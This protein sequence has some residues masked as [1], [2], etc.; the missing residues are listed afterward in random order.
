ML[1]AVLAVI[2]YLAARSDFGWMS[3]NP[4][5][6]LLLP[7]LIG[8]RYGVVAGLL[9][10]LLGGV[11]IAAVNAGT[12]GL[13]THQ[14]V[15]Q[16]P[17][18]FAL[19]ILTGYLAGECQRLLWKE[20]L[21]LRAQTKRQGDDNDRLR[22]ELE[23]A[24]ETRQEMQQ[25]LAL[26]HAEM[27]GLDEDLREVI[28]GASEGLFERFLTAAQQHTQVV[29]AAFYRR[30][31][32]ALQQVAVLHA[33]DRLP[34]TLSLAEVPL[35]RRALEERV[36]VSVAAAVECSSKQ[37]YLA[38]LPFEDS[39]GEGVL[40]IQDMPLKTFDWAHLAR[41]EVMLQWVLA[42][43]QN[44]DDLAGEG[45]QLATIKAFRSAVESALIAEQV[46]QVPSVVV[47]ADFLD[48]QGGL[49]SKMRRSLLKSLPSTA[50]AA[51]LT[52]GGSLVVL[53]P[54]AGEMEATALLRE[55]QG[56][57]VHLRASHYLVAG[58]AGLDEFWQHVAQA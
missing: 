20:N 13:N 31:G 51:Q 26:N 40:L 17:Y 6:W 36:L 58:T 15:Q 27:A 10:G 14:H 50:V 32:V 28:A 49:N 25:H 8:V 11:G 42:L 37:P 47:R 19:L 30:H 4:S 1:G 7:A 46:H 5:P 29:S 2:N 45:Q 56:T 48:A 53:L 38:A 24:R 21:S 9:A 43:K 41:L 12:S 54:F 18:F 55:W 39:M 57:D 16:H 52:D 3:L 34:L 35:V 23:I 44:R 33:T 22:A